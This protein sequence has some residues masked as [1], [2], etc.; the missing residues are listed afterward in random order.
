[1]GRGKFGL[2]FADRSQKFFVLGQLY[3]LVEDEFV[4]QLHP[5]EESTIETIVG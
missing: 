5:L 1:M 3:L 2:L 4:P